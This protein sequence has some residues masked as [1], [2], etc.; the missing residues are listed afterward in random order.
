MGECEIECENIMALLVAHPFFKKIKSFHFQY[1]I[2]VISKPWQET[3]Q[4]F[5]NIMVDLFN[6][7][8]YRKRHEILKRAGNFS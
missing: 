1:L 5:H 6:L 4:N 7:A 8:Y 2:P 3:R